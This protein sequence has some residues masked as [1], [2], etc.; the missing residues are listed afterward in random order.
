MYYWLKELEQITEMIQITE[1]T[2]FSHDI[3]IFG[4]AATQF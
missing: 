4:D 3:H 1:Q 2:N